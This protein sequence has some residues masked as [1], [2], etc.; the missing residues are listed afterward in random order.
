[1]VR[2]SAWSLLLRWSV[3]LLGLVTTVI[4]A[5]LLTPED[6]GIVSMALIVV[7]AIEM[8]AA[9]GQRY[10]II[11]HPNPTR[12]HFDTAWTLSILMGAAVALL[13]LAAAPISASYLEE[14]RA[15]AVMQW[16]AVGAFIRG[17]ENVGLISF[18]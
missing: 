14:P 18:Q 9:S 12:S 16:L 2:G 5:R 17:F 13:I 11:R 15:L 10:A 1:M 4:L 3:R 7:G 6:F 8:L